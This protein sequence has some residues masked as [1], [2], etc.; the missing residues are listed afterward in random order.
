MRTGRPVTAAVAVVS[1]LALGACGVADRPTVKVSAPSRSGSVL[2]AEA[3]CTAMPMDPKDPGSLEAMAAKPVASAIAGSAALS[4]LGDAV[5]RAG[6]TGTWNTARA[7][8]VFAPTN[9]AFAKIPSADRKRLMADK[10]ALVG[11]L[12]YHV[13]PERLGP[14]AVVG[15]HR[16]LQGGDV[17][18]QTDGQAMT[19]NTSAAVLCAN[20]Q[21]RNATVYIVDSVLSPRP[22]LLPSPSGRQR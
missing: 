18:V 14:V 22:D 21:T 6:L 7:V 20:V 11:M 1:C 5:K 17:V 8:T 9:R 3:G 16:S 13:L 19:V 10:R 15:S 2:P 4:S 12:L